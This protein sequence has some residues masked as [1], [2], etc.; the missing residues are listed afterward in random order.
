MEG[1]TETSESRLAPTD[2]WV[3]AHSDLGAG[4]V[5]WTRD[6]EVREITARP[7][8]GGQAIAVER[9]DHRSPMIYVNLP[10]EM[11]GTVTVDESYRT[12]PYDVAVRLVVDESGPEPR[13]VVDS[14]TVRRAGG[15]QV[16]A[17]AL[18]SLRLGD[19]VDFMLT[20]FPVIEWTAADGTTGDYLGTGEAAEVLRVSGRRTGKRGV[21]VNPSEVARVAAAAPPRGRV[22][23]V[24]THFGIG[25]RTAKRALAEAYDAGVLDRCRPTRLAGVDGA[26]VGP[27][28]DVDHRPQPMPVRRF[29]HPGRGVAEQVGNLLVRDAQV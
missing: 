23:A 2:R 28:G 14:V 1:D 15:A 27:G 13:A 18:R 22:R 16:T 8:V 5:R 26:P 11:T 6:G 10:A 4:R 19:L 17:G 25:E 29:D 21:G 20:R 24:A 9:D 3:I 12:E 7:G